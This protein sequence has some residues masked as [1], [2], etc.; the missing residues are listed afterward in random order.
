MRGGIGGQFA[1]VVPVVADAQSDPDIAV[2][3][4][5]RLMTVENVPVVVG[6][7]LQYRNTSTPWQPVAE[8]ENKK[9]F[10]VTIAISGTRCS[11]I[12]I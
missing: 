12:V 11:R 8:K 4:G 1:K 3:E 7:Q 6:L 2:R 9:I 5:Q 10:W